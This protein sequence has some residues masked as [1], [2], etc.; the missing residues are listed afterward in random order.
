M[1]LTLDD[2]IWKDVKDIPGYKV[3]NF[4]RILSCDIEFFT[5][6]GTKKSYK[7]GKILKPRK[8][9][10]GYLAVHTNSSSNYLIHRLVADAFLDN[11]LNKSQVNHIDGNKQNNQVINLEW[12]TPSENCK[13]AHKLGLRVGKSGEKNSMAKFSDEDIKTMR[14]L[15]KS[16]KV[17]DIAKLFKANAKYIS[18][19]TSNKVRI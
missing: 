8:V 9:A 11:P 6:N 16:M 14:Y 12:C 5:Y 18:A 3:S 4:G 13:H 7:K 19:V 15:R 2:E 1:N 10:H 17:V